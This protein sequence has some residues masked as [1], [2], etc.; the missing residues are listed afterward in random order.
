MQYFLMHKLSWLAFGAVKTLYTNYSSLAV[1][2]TFLLSPNKPTWARFDKVAQQI[3]TLN[4]NAKQR[5]RLLTATRAVP[6]HYTFTANNSG[7]QTFK[8]SINRTNGRRSKKWENAMN[9]LCTKIADFY[10][11]CPQAWQY[12]QVFFLISNIVHNSRAPL[13]K[14]LISFFSMLA[15]HTNM[16]HCNSRKSH[17]WD[18]ISPDNLDPQV[19]SPLHG[20]IIA[21][22]QYHRPS[23]CWFKKSQVIGP[24]SSQNA[25]RLSL[26]PKRTSTGSHRTK[27][28]PHALGGH[29]SLL[30]MLGNLVSQLCYGQWWMHACGTK[31]AKL[32]WE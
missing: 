12:P 28:C 13:C 10:T 3:C 6:V 7:L 26:S 21:I 18:F 32:L 4:M 15:L 25:G 5:W 24:C 22:T 2:L 8:C 30:V 17:I 9:V 29:R 20:A 16:N 1:R 11:T 27:T 14:G 19:L 23:L 31:A